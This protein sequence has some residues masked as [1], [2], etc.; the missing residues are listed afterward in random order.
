MS[1]FLLPHSQFV[2]VKTTTAQRRIAENLAQLEAW[3]RGAKS[4][5]DLQHVADQV[6]GFRQQVLGKDPE[7]EKP[8]VEKGKLRKLQTG[9]GPAAAFRMDMA[10]MLRELVANVAR[11]GSTEQTFT[12]RLDGNLYERGSVTG[13]LLGLAEELHP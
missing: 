3:L 7:R 11:D 6:E 4:K 10:T 13:A 9:L 1:D 12:W 5:T 8:A 2:G